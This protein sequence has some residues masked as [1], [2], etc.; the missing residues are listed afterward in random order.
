[1]TSQF[2]AELLKIRSTRTTVGLVVGMVGLILL[3]SLLTGLLTK[4]PNLV[5]TEDQR[6]LLLVGAYAG[7]FS[8]LAGI[9]LVTSEY[10][11]GTIKP[12]FLFTPRRSR[13]VVA[14]VA[15][16][17]LAGLAFGIV[18]TALGFG[19]GYACL[20]GRGIDYALNDRQ[21]ALLLVGTVVGT[22][23]W[24]GIGVGLGAILRSQ[25]A[26]IIGVLAWAFV[27]ENLLFA[28]LPGIGRFGPT[29]AENALIGVATE[30]LLR[31]TPGGLVVVAWAA[32]LS[33]LGITL[34]ARRDVD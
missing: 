30:H 34:V 16:G 22:A 15:A 9:M 8:A 28:F 12:T 2:R 29:H 1:M 24:G 4:A 11:Y 23:I 26:A 10:R 31:A 7:V 3:F 21:T 32:A 20:A 27:A 6:G 5:T 14:K 19:I 25:V 17:V 33:L 18:G 13:V